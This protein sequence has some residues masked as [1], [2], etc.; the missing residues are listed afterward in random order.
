ML[1]MSSL[2]TT[3][4]L[5]GGSSLWFNYAGVGIDLLFYFKVIIVVFIIIFLRA[6][7]PRFRFDQL[8]SL[9]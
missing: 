6:N 5:G 8:M 9:G 4:F 2:F 3:L 1:I 7:L